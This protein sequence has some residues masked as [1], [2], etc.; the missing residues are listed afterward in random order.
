MT[1]LR[2]RITSLVK[3]KRHSWLRS[4]SIQ[5]PRGHFVTVAIDAKS[6]LT[7]KTCP[8]V[9]E[10]K[11][12]IS[13][14]AL[15]F[16]FSISALPPECFWNVKSLLACMWPLSKKKT[17]IFLIQFWFIPFLW[18]L[19]L[20]FCGVFVVNLWFSSRIWAAPIRGSNTYF[21]LGYPCFSAKLNEKSK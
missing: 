3:D 9:E 15:F 17:F 5:Y 10:L 21:S 20:P 12:K 4:W 8:L 13:E 19:G 7:F 18:L 11:L 6:V 2:F 14:I 1:L 16:M